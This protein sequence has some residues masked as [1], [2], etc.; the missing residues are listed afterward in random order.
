MMKQ[1]ELGRKIVSLRKQ[2]GLT[3]EELVDKCNLNVRTLQRIESG[4]VNP[5]SHT[6]KSIFEALEYETGSPAT[7]RYQRTKDFLESNFKKYYS[8]IINEE[9]MTHTKVFFQRFF[10]ATGFIYLIF[11]ISRLTWEAHRIRVEELLTLIIPAAY[12][13]F[14]IFE[15]QRQKRKP[16][17]VYN[18]SG[19][20][21]TTY[22]LALGIVWFF[23]LLSVYLFKITIGPTEFYWTL[24]L[25]LF[26]A[27]S[28]LF[29]K[30]RNAQPDSE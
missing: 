16:E 20:L 21:L 23:S 11:A 18:Y 3:Q 8:Q 26:Y 14:R 7:E 10:L 19:S 17:E 22:F 1:P 6:I 24:F 4:E 13:T 30:K 28:T 29:R 12:A 27:L 2:L 5:R 25:P 15:D 9:T